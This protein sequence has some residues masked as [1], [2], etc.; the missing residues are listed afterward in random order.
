MPKI[1]IKNHRD[2]HGG[3]TI[4]N[5]LDST[6]YLWGQKARINL[7]GECCSRGLLSWD[8][9]TICTT[10]VSLK[11]TWKKSKTSTFTIFAMFWCPV[12]T[13]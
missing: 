2:H 13:I 1:N 3:P 7:L 6:L 10:Q 5:G 12:I 11:K 9:Q 8:Y 4:L